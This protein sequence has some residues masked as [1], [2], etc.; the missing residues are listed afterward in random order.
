MGVIVVPGKHMAGY[1]LEETKFVTKSRLQQGPH[2]MTL[3]SG[4]FLP[5]LRVEEK[6]NNPGANSSHCHNLLRLTYRQAGGHPLDLDVA[7]QTKTASKPLS[8]L[9]FIR[10]SSER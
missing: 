8:F 1:P 2:Y 3:V 9:N 7:D 10:N 6:T 4:N 5:T